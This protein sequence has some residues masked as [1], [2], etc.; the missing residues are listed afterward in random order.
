M[1]LIFGGA[2]LSVV[3]GQGLTVLHYAAYFGNTELARTLIEH[4]SAGLVLCEAPGGET[5]LCLACQSGH[6][7]VA[8]ALIK[9]GGEELLLKTRNDGVSCLYIA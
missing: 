3:D 9:T 1:K 5:S 4:E 7:E 2:D 8:N 6:L